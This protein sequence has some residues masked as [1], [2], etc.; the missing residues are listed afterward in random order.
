MRQL[1][2]AL[3]RA[4]GIGTTSVKLGV[5]LS[6]EG[7]PSDTVVLED[8]PRWC[9][10]AA[11]CQQALRESRWEPARDAAGNPMQSQFPFRCTFGFN[12]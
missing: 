7:T 5:W 12:D 8:E 1:Y 4:R 6:S 2:P 10:F 11:A 9:G 3:A